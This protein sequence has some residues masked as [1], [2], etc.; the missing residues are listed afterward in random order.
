M[1][2]VLRFFLYMGAMLGSMAL[3]YV[4]VLLVVSFLTWTSPMTF[5]AGMNWF[6]VRAMVLVAGFIAAIFILAKA[7]AELT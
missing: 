1:K 6:T 5:L 3:A 7:G 4:S 2:Y